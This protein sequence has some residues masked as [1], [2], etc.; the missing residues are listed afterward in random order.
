M[1]EEIKKKTN[2]SVWM[3][4]LKQFNDGR[5]WCV[6]KKG[7]PEYDAVKA[8]ADQM[9]SEIIKAT[10]VP[11]E[12][13]KKV[14]KPRVKAVVVETPEEKNLQPPPAPVKKVR[15][16]KEKLSSETDSSYN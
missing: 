11:E 10:P 3:L 16:K 14:R 2:T 12:P 4:A 15:R 13:M 5:Q 7:T 8:L 9:K 1:T 6:P